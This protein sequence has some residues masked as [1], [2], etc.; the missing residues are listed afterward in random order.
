[1]ALGNGGSPVRG[2]R[3]PANAGWVSVGIDHD[4]AEFAAKTIRRWWREMGSQRYPR[5]TRAADHGRRRRQQRVARCGCG[6]WNCS[7]WPTSSGCAI[8]VCHFPPGTSKWNKIEH[9]LFSYITDN[10]RGRPL[11]SHE[12]I[13]NLIAATTTKAGFTVGELDTNSYPPAAR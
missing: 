1:M 7:S 6:S 4:T 2:L 3:L 9:R 11:V 10:W 12:V 13:V 8:T 5:A